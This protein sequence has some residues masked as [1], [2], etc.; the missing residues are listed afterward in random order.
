MN[1]E[2]PKNAR[3]G[4]ALLAVLFIVMAITLIS[5]GFLARSD[6]EL[7]CATNVPIR[8]QMDYLAQSGLNHAK[9]LIINPQDVDISEDGYWGQTG[10]DD[11]LGLGSDNDYYDIEVNRD[12]SDPDNNH[13]NYTIVSHAY[14]LNGADKISNS[15]LAGNLRL[16]PCIALWT[17]STL[18]G[19]PRVTVHGDTICGGDLRGDAAYNG[20]AFAVG[21]IFAGNVLGDSTADVAPEDM[22]IIAPSI[23]MSDLNPTYWFEGSSYSAEALPPSLSPEPYE[24]TL[25]NPAGIYYRDGN[26]QLNGDVTI[27]GTLI[28]RDNLIINGTGNTITAEKNFPAMVVGMKTIFQNDGQLTVNGLVQINEELYIDSNCTEDAFF[29]VTGGLFIVQNAITING[30]PPT[31]LTLKIIAA[32]ELAALL[33]QKADK[34]YNRWTPAGG[35]FFKKIGRPEV[36]E[37]GGQIIF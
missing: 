7:A 17:G 25:G 10:L 22:P 30:G 6:R 36:A 13:S 18:R 3:S 37:E 31:D 16:D 2:K 24:L 1:N 29:N 19:F 15:I 11:G 23:V 14:R 35:A 21:Y 34:T 27:N 33:Y 12:I 8:M 28:V 9:A 26:L 20:D 32:P 4:L 5:L